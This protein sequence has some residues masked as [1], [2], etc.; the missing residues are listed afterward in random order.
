[1]IGY[2][3]LSQFLLDQTRPINLPEHVL[4]PLQATVAGWHEEPRA[5]GWLNWLEDRLT[6]RGAWV[7]T[8]NRP[9]A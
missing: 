4:N 1:M 8:L 9:T 6:T 5:P 2:H 3:L 7:G